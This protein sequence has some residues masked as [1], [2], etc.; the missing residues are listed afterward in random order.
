MKQGKSVKI[1]IYKLLLQ[2]IDYMLLTADSSIYFFHTCL[3]LFAF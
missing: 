2:Y 3:F 1:S